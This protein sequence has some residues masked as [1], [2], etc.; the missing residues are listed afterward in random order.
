MV[1]QSIPFKNAEFQN[2]KIF[3]K[4][5]GAFP[6]TPMQKPPPKTPLQVIV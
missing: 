4:T 6:L 3:G 1:I 2:L 5:S